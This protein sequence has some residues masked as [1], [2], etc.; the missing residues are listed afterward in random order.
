MLG[1][2][3][4]QVRLYRIVDFVGHCESCGIHGQYLQPIADI[5]HLSRG[6]ILDQLER[7]GTAGDEHL[8]V[9]GKFEVIWLIET[10]ARKAEVRPG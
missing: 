10:T 4:E 8:L 6:Q 3:P 1:P 9:T 7:I 2:A 5:E